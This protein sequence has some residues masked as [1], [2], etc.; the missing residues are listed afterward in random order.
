[1]IK[2][3]NICLPKANG[4]EILRRVRSRGHPASTVH[5]IQAIGVVAA[6]DFMMELDLTDSDDDLDITKAVKKDL[7]HEDYI[8]STSDKLLNINSPS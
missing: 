3:K 4:A 6:D 7:G 5:I 2:I 8:N 1:M